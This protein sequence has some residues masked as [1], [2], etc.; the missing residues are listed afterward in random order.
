[1]L[2][3]KSQFVFGILILLLVLSLCLPAAV[4]GQ[5]E[6]TPPPS[7]TPETIPFTGTPSPTETVPSAFGEDPTYTETSTPTET[8]T[9]TATTS[10][11]MTSTPLV[12]TTDVVEP[13]ADSAI[14]QVLV[15]FDEALSEQQRSQYLEL[16]N[17]R[18][19]SE[20]PELGVS[21][22]AV[23]IGQAVTVA[24]ELNALPG[25]VYAEPN[26]P[27]SAFDLIPDDPGWPNQYNMRAIHAPQGWTWTTG[28][29]WVTIAILD[30]GVELSHPDL[31]VKI[32][33]GYDF[34][35][36]DDI[37]QDDNGHGT[38]VAAIAAASTNNGVGMAGVDPGANI[39]PVKV[40]DAFGNGTNANVAAGITWATDQG[41]Q[42]INLSL[43]GSFPS[44]VLEDAVNYAY[45]RGVIMVAAA[46]N[47]GVGSVL[48][49]AAYPAV[50]A[51]AATD[52]SNNRANF[53]N[54][55]AEVDVAAPGANIY[56][57]YPGG[58]YGYRS[59]TSMAAPHVAGLAAILRG[60]PGN[61]PL[62]VVT[63]IE[64][65]C[66]DLGA[67]GWD[68]YYGFGLI[69]MDAAIQ[70]GWPTPTPTYTPT[71]TATSISPPL[72]DPTST[73]IIIL[74]P[75]TPAFTTTRTLIYT[76][77]FTPTTSAVVS[78]EMSMLSTAEPTLAR[79]AP[80]PSATPGSQIK[81]MSPAPFLPCLGIGLIAVGTGFFWLTLMVM[82]G[83]PR[84]KL[85]GNR[86]HKLPKF[87]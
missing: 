49:P 13:P 79:I 80:I 35:N 22:L 3:C 46:G 56:S 60:I 7:L 40:L 69:Q 82:R 23:P 31:F 44:S 64:S 53:S 67:P 14:D 5:T 54:F 17:A 77:T 87:D 70:L 42:V 39:M 2:Q 50:I 9:P 24:A 63:I 65:T 52:N 15:K 76:V 66:L 30:T 41:A 72:V 16:N 74:Y 20:I 62:R 61:G 28:A 71:V 73:S 6:E 84:T 38:H 34:V 1:M 18:L 33:P 59:G 37:A 83:N 58:G 11:T 78:P 48:Y 32:L 12:P 85:H 21:V 86:L 47:S 29:T 51:V 57:A 27:V 36:R 8:P 4:L 25:V 43:G 19:L 26:Y 55:G 81:P 45:E 75:Y 68:A 10:P